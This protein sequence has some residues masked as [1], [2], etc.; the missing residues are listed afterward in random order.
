MKKV[1]KPS[2]PEEAVYYSDFKG[3][4]FGNF[5]PEATLSFQFDYGSK[6]DGE[7]LTVHLSDEEAEQLLDFLK[8]KMSEDFKES[9]RKRLANQQNNLNNSIQARDYNQSNHYSNSCNL[10]N[11]LISNE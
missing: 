10:L 11:R 7:T 8:T 3:K 2:K 9:L 6:Y 4:S 1:I 5:Y